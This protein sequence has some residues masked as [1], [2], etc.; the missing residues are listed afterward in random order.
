[1]LSK[2]INA[3]GRL[4]KNAKLQR[5]FLMLLC[6]RWRPTSFSFSSPRKKTEKKKMERM[7]EILKFVSW[8][9]LCLLFYL[10]RSKFFIVFILQS[11]KQ[12][13]GNIIPLP[14]Y[15]RVQVVLSNYT[16]IF[17][18]ATSV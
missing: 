1:M 14:E 11:F 2:K 17:L 13:R 4:D 5:T 10:N 3:T 9:T 6:C 8:I 18:F 12:I 15:N 16:L 7:N